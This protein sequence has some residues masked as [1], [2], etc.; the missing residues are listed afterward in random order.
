[1][2]LLVDRAGPQSGI[3]TEAFHSHYFVTQSVRHVSRPRDTINV[4]T[5]FYTSY[6]RYP[7]WFQFITNKCSFSK[8]TA[9]FSVLN[10]KRKLQSKPTSASSYKCN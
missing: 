8:V 4:D 9:D 2:S 10:Q 5:K 7:V 1:M 6:F 3:M